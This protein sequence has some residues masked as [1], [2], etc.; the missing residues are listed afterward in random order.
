MRLSPV[1]N[2][3]KTIGTK[4]NRV[5]IAILDTGVSK[6]HPDIAAAQRNGSIARYQGFPENLDP[7]QDKDGHGTQGASVLLKTAPDATLLVARVANDKR[8]IPDINDYSAVEK[9]TIVGCL[10]EVVPFG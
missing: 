10:C 8:Q 3:V 7:L 5:R 1:Q 6:D 9:V 4:D 2:I